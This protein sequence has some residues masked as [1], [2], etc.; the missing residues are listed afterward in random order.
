MLKQYALALMSAEIAAALVTAAA[1]II[2]AIPAVSVYNFLRRRIEKFESELVT[3]QEVAKP[4]DTLA[5][6]PSFRF[7]QTLPLQSRFSGLP[8]FA[9]LAAPALACVVALF[10]FFEP[11]ES[12]TGLP[13]RLLP[14]GSLDKHHHAAKP[15]LISLVKASNSGSTAVRVQSKEIPLD[16]LNR[17]VV[18][19]IGVSP[20]LRVYVEAEGALPWADVVRV[21][22][23]VRSSD[24]EVFLLTT[25]PNSSSRASTLP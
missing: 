24:A 3:T 11:Y 5:S 2:V 17:A 18:Q 7:A 1:G 10:T 8:P 13:V 16:N 6:R 25:T 23:L 15:I 20:Q 14:I 4:S 9:L 22:D 12:P 19:K 21:L